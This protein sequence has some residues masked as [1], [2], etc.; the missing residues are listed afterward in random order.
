M[1]HFLECASL[2][3]GKMIWNLK[4][5]SSVGGVCEFIGADGQTGACGTHIVW[6]LLKLLI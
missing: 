5:L 2:L 1:V 4:L 6:V 3:G